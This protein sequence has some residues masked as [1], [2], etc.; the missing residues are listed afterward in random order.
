[1]VEDNNIQ[2]KKLFPRSLIGET[3][4][5]RNVAKMCIRSRYSSYVEY[6]LCANIVGSAALKR[7]D[8]IF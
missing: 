4:T 2:M 7:V 5:K 8:V 3:W 6:R 1:M